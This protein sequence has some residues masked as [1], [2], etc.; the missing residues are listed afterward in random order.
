MTNRDILK[1]IA[2]NRRRGYQL[3]NEHKSAIV[4][5]RTAGLKWKEVASRNSVGISTAQYVFETYTTTESTNP[6]PR[7]GRPKVFNRLQERKIVRCVRSHQKWTYNQ[8]ITETG[9]P[10]GRTAFRT[11]LH[12]HNILQWIAKK[13]PHLAE[14]H[15]RLRLAFCLA[16]RGRDW[17]KVIFLDECSV[18]KGKGKKEALGLG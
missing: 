5:S 12:K 17:S 1:P 10:I 18:E 8:V 13:R 6:R 4:A 16:N 7:K 3:S 2:A 9:V 15:R 14:E 11:L